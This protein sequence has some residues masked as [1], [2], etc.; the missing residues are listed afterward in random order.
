MANLE[1]SG[2]Q[3]HG[4][5]P[6]TTILTASVFKT[7]EEA[8]SLWEIVAENLIQCSVGP[9]NV[10]PI[11]DSIFEELA[12]NAVQHSSSQAGSCATVECFT[13]NDEILY[14]IG[15]VDLGIGILSSLH[16]NPEHQHIN[17]EYDAISRAI[18]LDVTGTLQNRGAGLHH[19]TDRVQKSSG[20]LVIISG[21]GFLMI[22]NGQGPFR[23]DFIAEK[24]SR[25]PGTLV[26]AAIPIPHL[27]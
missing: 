1:L 26:L 8:N 22:R 24:W 5:V 13:S 20:E 10:W 12:L 17:D 23:G 11:V 2:Q 14:V 9:S 19:I 16:N 6:D 27:R 3:F 21:D 15:V 4:H 7:E 18:E 25:H